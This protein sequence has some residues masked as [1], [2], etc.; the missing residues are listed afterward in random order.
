MKGVKYN[1]RMPCPTDEE[2]KLYEKV[3][4]NECIES[5]KQHLKKYNHIE[6]NITKD[7]VYNLI[8]RR[9]KSHK[10]LRDLCDIKVCEK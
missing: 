7:I 1:L 9:E 6:M 10:I 8:K 5:I 3:N 4:M 2:F